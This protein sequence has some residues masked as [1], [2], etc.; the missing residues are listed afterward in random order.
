M[1]SQVQPRS[2]AGGD[3][4]RT[5]LSRRAHDVTSTGDDEEEVEGEDEEGLYNNDGPRE[6]SRGCF[7]NTCLLVAVVTVLTA[8]AVASSQVLAVIYD[9]ELT[10]QECAI[11][12]YSVCFCISICLNELGWTETIRK[13]PLLASWVGRGFYYAFV[14]LLNLDQM[15][16][17]RG[18]GGSKAAS[19]VTEDAGCV[20]VAIGA[21][22]FVMGIG[23]C[24]ARKE[25]R[26]AK[27]QRLVAQVEYHDR[28]R[29]EAR[30]NV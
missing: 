17:F 12:I 13:T 30:L 18:G 29:E 11:R 25:K 9:N 21:L 22:Y 3:N 16:E 5:P 26:L 14:G 2:S 20:M 19:A 1:L 6:I 8:V 10:L 28:L 23:C 7:L 15:D 24:R 27:Y 4:E